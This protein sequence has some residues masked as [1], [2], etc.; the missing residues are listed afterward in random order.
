RCAFN[1]AMLL[2]Q[3]GCQAAAISA[4]APIFPSNVNDRERAGGNLMETNRNYRNRAAQRIASSYAHRLNFPMMY[5]WKWQAYWKYPFQSWGGTFSMEAHAAA[6]W[7]L[8]WASLL[9]G[10]LS[11][12]VNMICFPF[13]CWF[14]WIGVPLAVASWRHR[15]HTRSWLT[16]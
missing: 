11:I 14:L 3:N 12:L 13:R 7:E 15:T 2:Q 16:D 10:P 9:A 1:Y 5:Y 4:L 8:L 6:S